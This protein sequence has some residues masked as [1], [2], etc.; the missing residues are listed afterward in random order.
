MD[1]WD[2]NL[3]RLQHIS[4]QQGNAG[5]SRPNFEIAH[6]EILR[7][8]DNLFENNRRSGH[9]QWNGRQ[10]RNAFQVARSL[11]YSDAMAGHPDGEPL[12]KLR[13]R[14]EVRHFHLVNQITESFE[15]YH[16]KIFAGLTGADL[17]R[18][19]EERDD[20][21]EDPWNRDEPPGP[22]A[23]FAAGADPEGRPHPRRR[24]IS[25][26]QQ[27]LYSGSPD[28]ARD[29]L[30][31][32]PPPAHARRTGSGGGGGGGWTASDAGLAAPSPS[33]SPHE[34]RYYDPL[35]VGSRGQDAGGPAA[36]YTQ[37]R[38]P[39]LGHYARGGGAGGGAG[40]PAITFRGASPAGT[41]D[42]HGARHPSPGPAAAGMAEGWTIGGG[43]PRLPR[44]GSS[45]AVNEFPFAA[46]RPGDGDGYEAT[47]DQAGNEYDQGGWRD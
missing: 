4:N 45:R 43:G 28:N 27:H 34:T 46:G 47:H 29:E 16:R 32:P 12:S 5:S 22:D 23:S 18:E 30:Y 11:A 10:I 17:A 7:F 41:A 21:H 14:L 9:P 2:L 6:N 25:E 31:G 36:P 37:P 8:A 35:G 26:Q 33:T 13:P 39:H 20:D 42:Y 24:P 3:K 1:I 44:H 38:S 15:V 40:A 19:M